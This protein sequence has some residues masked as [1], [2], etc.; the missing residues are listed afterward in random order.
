MFCP[1]CNNETPDDSYRCSHCGKIVTENRP[2]A[3]FKFK[4]A[5]KSPFN[6]TNM[7]AALAV[8]GLAVVLY[9]VLGGNKPANEAMNSYLPGSEMVVEQYLQ[10]GKFNILFF[11][12][13]KSKPCKKL[14]PMLKKLEKKRPDIVT[15][16]LD[17]DREG[18]TEIDLESPLAKQFQ[19]DQVPFFLVYNQDG[20][21]IQEGRPAAAMVFQLLKKE[22][23]Q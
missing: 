18:M 4:V 10:K 22:G 17:I 13:Q 15:A 12:S 23:I 16:R 9:F 1:H 7:I 6:A 21:R 5:K 20:L 3:Q 14:L 19:I 2:H 8:L 11:Y